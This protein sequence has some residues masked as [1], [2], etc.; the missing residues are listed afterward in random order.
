MAWTIERRFVRRATT[1]GTKNALFMHLPLT[2][3]CS[4]DKRSQSRRVLAARTL[5]TQTSVLKMINAVGVVWRIDALEGTARDAFHMTAIH[6]IMASRLVC[7]PNLCLASTLHTFYSHCVFAIPLIFPPILYYTEDACTGYKSCSKCTKDRMCGWCGSDKIC[8]AK[9]TD[10]S[11]S[12]QG[13]WHERTLF[14]DGDV[15]GTPIGAGAN[16]TAAAKASL[17]SGHPKTR[18][19]MKGRR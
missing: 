3:V 16:S 10:K 6:G 4:G 2:F 11:V 15:C 7:S 18:V 19:V 8:Q 13:S 5:Q 17:A 1:C 12:C 9:A 14:T